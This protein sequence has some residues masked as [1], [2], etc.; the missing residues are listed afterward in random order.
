MITL[1]FPSTRVFHRDFSTHHQPVA[2]GRMTATCRVEK[3]GI[4]TTWDSTTESTVPAAP[5]VIIASSICAVQE[6]MRAKAADQAGQVVTERRYRVSLPADVPKIEVK[7][8][9]VILTATG[10]AN[11][12]GRTFYIDDVLFGSERFERDLI[13]LDNLD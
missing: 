1:P 8:H 11:M 9:V 4:G 12:V 13:C 7:S 3:P 2:N 6:Y 5:T 10:D